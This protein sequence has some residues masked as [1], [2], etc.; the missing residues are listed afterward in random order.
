MVV[1]VLTVQN[2]KVNLVIHKLVVAILQQIIVLGVLGEHVQKHVEAE[3]KQ[4]QE[5][6]QKYQ[7]MMEV[8][9]KQ[10]LRQVVNLVILELAVVVQ[11]QIMD[12]GV[13]GELVQKHVEQD[14]NHEQEHIQ[15]YQ[16]MMEVR[17]KQELRQVL[18]I[19]IHNLAVVAQQQ[20]MDLGVVGEAVQKHVEQEHKLEQEHIQRNQLMMEALVKQVLIQE[21]KIVIH[22]VVVAAQQQLMDLGVAGEAVQKHAVEEHKPEQEHIQRNQLMMEVHVKRVQILEAKHVILRLVI[23]MYI[24]L[25]Q[26]VVQKQGHQDYMRYSTAKM[27]RL[28]Q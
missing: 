12:L 25:Q 7:I 26:L 17:A 16:I 2:Q 23:A 13:I 28:V 5:H 3:H 24:V 8:R 22:K 21:A 9:A 19:V 6:I 4:E 1:F 11:Q 14:R 18:K 20:L 15:K 10:E 27:E